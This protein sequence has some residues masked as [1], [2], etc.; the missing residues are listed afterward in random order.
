M[1]LWAQETRLLYFLYGTWQGTEIFLIKTKAK[2]SKTK[3]RVLKIQLSLKWTIPCLN[4]EV[5][6]PVRKWAE[7]SWGGR[8]ANEECWRSG[9]GQ[10]R[11]PLITHASH[12]PSGE[13]EMDRQGFQLP[14]TSGLHETAGLSQRTRSLQTGRF[15]SSLKCWEERAEHS[16]EAE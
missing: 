2:E 11:V 4:V 13:G 14:T 5:S 12:E 16:E 9:G 7:N 10:F 6:F 1:C 3:S 15:P 8:K